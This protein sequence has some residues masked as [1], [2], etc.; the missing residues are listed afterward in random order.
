MRF[1]KLFFLNV[2]KVHLVSL[3][4]TKV[5]ISICFIFY[6]A[7][8]RAPV[9]MSGEAC[10]SKVGYLN[11]L[12]SKFLI[13]DEFPPETEAL[14][15]LVANVDYER[16]QSLGTVSLGL[17]CLAHDTCYSERRPKRECDHELKRSWIESCRHTYEKPT[18]DSLLCKLACEEFIKLMSIAQSYNQQG[19]CPSCE[20]YDALQN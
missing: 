17:S 1:F 2:Q 18:I 12:A 15:N 16:C 6:L 13:P 7:L 14:R 4:M 5:S 19:F 11:Q 10:G 3:S 8:F 20:A 9:A